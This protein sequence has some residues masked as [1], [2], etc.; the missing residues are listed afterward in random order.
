MLALQRS[1]SHSSAYATRRSQ[2][3]RARPDVVEAISSFGSSIFNYKSRW[4]TGIWSSVCNSGASFFRARGNLEI[5]HRTSRVDSSNFS[6]GKKAVAALLVNRLEE[7]E[8]RCYIQ[9]LSWWW[10]AWLEHGL[11]SSAIPL[12]PPFNVALICD[13]VLAASVP[14]EVSKTVTKVE[15]TVFHWLFSLAEG[16]RRF[17][18][19]TSSA[20]DDQ[21]GIYYSNQTKFSCGPIRPEGQTSWQPV[22]WLCTN[23]TWIKLTAS[24]TGR[25]RWISDTPSSPKNVWGMSLQKPARTTG[26]NRHNFLASHTLLIQYTAAFTIYVVKITDN[27]SDCRSFKM[28]ITMYASAEPSPARKTCG[29]FHCLH[30]SEMKIN[31]ETCVSLAKMATFSWSHWANTR[32]TWKARRSRRTVLEQK[33]ESNFFYRR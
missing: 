16:T 20:Y 3:Y 26:G 18:V 30:Q 27:Q 25:K 1:Y 10:L 24:K 11:K 5:L 17:A 23:G 22:W 12:S 14:D 4:H 29:N 19:M 33:L 28:C 31:F 21:Y 13:V 15:G 8:R 2:C 9:E 7:T 32:R 6:R